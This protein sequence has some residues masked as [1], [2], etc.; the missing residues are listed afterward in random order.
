MSE[1]QKQNN[2]VPHVN[3]YFHLFHFQQNFIFIFIKLV[4]VS[5]FC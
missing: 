5:Y 4:R 3:C 2:Y 1:K